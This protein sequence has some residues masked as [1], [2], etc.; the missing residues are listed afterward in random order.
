MLGWRTREPLVAAA[1]DRNFLPGGGML[2]PVV[3]IDG[4]AAGTWSL[5]P[6]AAQR[7]VTI[8]WFGHHADS[9]ELRAE[10]RRVE[11]FLRPG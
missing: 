8:N 6:R 2:R 3:L 7:T 4:Q 11:A 9:P 10:K 5:S 1:H